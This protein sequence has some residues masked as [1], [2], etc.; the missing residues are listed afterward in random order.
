MLGIIDMNWSVVFTIKLYWNQS[1]ILLSTRSLKCH[2]GVQSDSAMVPNWN[3]AMAHSTK[4]EW[5]CQR[6]IWSNPIFSW[7]TSFIAMVMM[8][9][10]EPW[11][12]CPSK[13]LSGT[14]SSLR[15][16]LNYHVRIKSLG[17][18]DSLKTEFIEHCIIWTSQFITFPCEDDNLYAVWLVSLFN[19][20]C[21]KIPIRQCQYSKESI[22]VHKRV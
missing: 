12:G 9:P 2:P 19:M 11:R 13:V 20:E 16:W 4:I 18:R 14:G 21:N 8:C 6:Y 7:A 3:T 17:D 5:H 1:C 15:N 22:I 10:P